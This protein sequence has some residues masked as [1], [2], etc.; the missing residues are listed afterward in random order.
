M[1]F[2][3]FRYPVK[4]AG[5]AFVVTALCSSALGQTRPF[6]GEAHFPQFRQVSGLSG[7][8]YGL[9]LDGW[10][11]LDGP[12]ALSTPLG[13]ALGHDQVRATGNDTFFGFNS[14]AHAN[15]TGKIGLMYGHTF[16]SF[17]LAYTYFIKSNAGD[18]ST[19]LQLSYD[20]HNAAIPNVS[21]GVQDIVGNGGSA[22]Q[23]Q[24]TDN[25]SSRSFFGALTYKVPIGPTGSTPLYLSGGWG[26]R[27]FGKGFASA[28]YQLA[29]PLRIFTEFDG[30]GFNEGFL[31][32]Y[33]NHG[34][35]DEDQ[36]QHAFEADLMLGLIQ[37]HYPTVGVTLGF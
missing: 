6:L 2:W 23:F 19:N 14:F 7:G 12:T 34:M 8:G 9:D 13:V 31:L 10:G 37:G 26:T 35:N 21:F 24:P 17:N 11:S 22:G 32:A 1:Q 25:E 15:S 20:P 30:F 28:T 27:R 4:L 33:R 16:G 18:A 5:V 29:G 3:S 36:P